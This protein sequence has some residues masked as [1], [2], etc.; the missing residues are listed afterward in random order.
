[1]PMLPSGQWV[2]GPND[3]HINPKGNLESGLGP[4]EPD[5]RARRKIGGAAAAAQARLDAMKLE[6][7]AEATGLTEREIALAEKEKELARR[8]AR[9]VAAENKKAKRGPA[10]DL[11]GPRANA[12]STDDESGDESDDPDKE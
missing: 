12:A 1:M 4:D 11:S 7:Q 8:E 6:L 2:P 3:Y 5:E 9:L 10:V